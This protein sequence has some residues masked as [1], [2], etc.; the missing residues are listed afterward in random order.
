MKV[1]NK[2]LDENVNE[3]PLNREVARTVLANYS[4]A[5]NKERGKDY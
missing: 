1:Y 3:D 2:L 5:K 4:I